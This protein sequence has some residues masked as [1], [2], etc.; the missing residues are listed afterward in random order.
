MDKFKVLK[1]LGDGAF[2]CVHMAQNSSTGEIVAIKKMKQKFSTWEQCT[3][4]RELKSLAKLNNHSNIVKLKE[5]IRDQATEELNFVFEYMESNMH[6]KIKEREGKPFPEEDVKA[7]TFQILS[8]L[9]HMHKHGFFHRDLKP[10]NLLCMGS[11]VKIADF[12]LARET[13]SLP[14]YTEYVSTRWY[15]APEVLLK[16]HNYSSPIDIWAVGTIMAELYLLYPLFPGTSEVDQ[17]SKICA[18]LGSPAC[19]SNL[20]VVS[21]GMVGSNLRVSTPLNQTT[22]ESYSDSMRP[23]TCHSPLL[24]KNTITQ[25]NSEQMQREKCVG[26]GPWIEG[27]KLAHAM[28]FKFPNMAPIPLSEIIVPRGVVGNVVVVSQEALQLIAD[29]LLFDPNRRLTAHE[30]LQNP[31]FKSLNPSQNLTRSSSFTKNECAIS[32][33]QSKAC[34]TETVKAAV[35]YV[36]VNVNACDSILRPKNS[37]DSFDF[38]SDDD[39]DD[40]LLGR[41]SPRISAY[42]NT[43]SSSSNKTQ[44]ESFQKRR[45]ET[46]ALGNSRTLE[47]SDLNSKFEFASTSPSTAA[48]GA[49]LCYTSPK[50]SSR[51]C[52]APIVPGI[53]PQTNASGTS[54]F[55]STENGFPPRDPVS[56]NRTRLKASLSNSDLVLGLIP[57]LTDNASSSSALRKQYRP[58]PEIGKSA[59]NV[60]SINSINSSP[61]PMIS[62]STCVS[63]DDGGG[64]KAMK[65]VVPY[66][67]RKA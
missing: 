1:Q 49:S 2:G 34:I 29:M 28:G 47:S 16:N 65:P 13:R 6:Q 22:R 53:R 32:P 27:I 9:V 59:N 44:Y 17:L 62:A 4:L 56:E 11:V 20:G 64:Q 21:G 26:G 43:T 37:M 48:A 5:V 67:S 52:P 39:D 24:Q 41:G 36:P 54:R 46:D 14:P 66:L 25:Q 42:S 61:S 45:P 40:D 23:Q 35:S 30:A 60:N 33:M 51:A 57:S 50:A 18:V 3:Q 7:F 8:G 10:E 38:L 55:S 12:G 31:W 58:L 19:D 15:R 63:S